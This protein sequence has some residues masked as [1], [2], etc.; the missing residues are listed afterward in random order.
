MDRIHEVGRGLENRSR[1]VRRAAAAL[2]ATFGAAA[3]PTAALRLRSDRPEV[4]EAA[5]L[6]LGGIG[7]R[8]AVQLLR[9][10]L[11]PLF[12]RTRLNL[13]A[14]DALRH[15]DDATDPAARRALEAWLIDSNRR[16]IRSVFIVKSAF[17]NPRDVKFLHALTRAREPRTRSNAF[18]ALINMP[19]KQFIQPVM[20]LLEAAPAAATGSTARHA[21]KPILPDAAMTID[22]ATAHDHWARLLATRVL[23]GRVSG[24]HSDEEEAMLDLV[25]FLKTTPLFSAVPL[26]DI[27]RF[28]RLA[29]P[30]TKKAGQGIVDAL[31]PVRHVYIVRSGIAHLVL[32]GA[33][34]E[35]LG[36][37]QSF[38]DTA[39]FGEERSPVSLRAAT[40]TVLLRFPLSLV[41]DLIAENPDVLG[42]LVLDLQT[43]LSALYG[44]VSAATTCATANTAREQRVDHFR[45]SPVTEV[46]ATAF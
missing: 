27:A 22:K 30:V 21:G 44:R 23:S 41:A 19:T 14:L 31:E 5:I 11:Q 33:V 7:T 42:F 12:Q 38:G 20:P 25:L 6:A 4:A 28:A 18:E 39:L 34:V 29:E 9:E 3:V 35:T 24:S 46:P 45:P 36:S 40:E 10:H 26:E 8:K 1:A 37:R 2:L 13:E 15:L 16:I 17:G 32:D 43:R